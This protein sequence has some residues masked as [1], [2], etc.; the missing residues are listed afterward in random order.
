VPRISDIFTNVAVYVYQCL[1]D[2]SNGE[3]FGG[4]GFLVAMPLEVNKEWYSFYAVTNRHVV[5]K[6]GTPVLRL[7]R[8]DGSVEC[9]PTREDQWLFHPGG[10]DVAVMP[11]DIQWQEYKFFAFSIKDFVTEKRIADE[12]IGIGDDTVMIGRFINH[13]GCQRNAPAVR[14]GNIAMMH[15]EP[16]VSEETGI[17]QESFLVEVRSLPGYSGS[18]VL[19]WSPCAINDM[20]RSRLGAGKPNLAWAMATKET[21]FRAASQMSEFTVKQLTSPK[22]PYLLGIDWCHIPRKAPIRSRDGRPIDDGWYVQEN[23]GMAGVIPAWKIADILNGEELTIQR[24]KQDEEM[25]KQ[26]SN[27]A[28]ALDFAERPTQITV[29]GAKIPIPTQEQFLDDLTKAS[30]KINPGG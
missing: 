20:S 12:D 4:S 18:A 6:A 10:D 9:I 23:T 19:L 17:A 3:A 25:T 14:F 11:L 7:N 30:R 16:I 21:A 22:G 2:A 13:D 26:K 28:S 8:K 29:H 5:A 24:Q 1:E 15:H 27:A